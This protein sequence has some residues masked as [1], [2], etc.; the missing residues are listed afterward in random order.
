MKWIALF[1]FIIVVFII[2]VFAIIANIKIIRKLM[3]A[4]A[5]HDATMAVYKEKN[6]MYEQWLRIMYKGQSISK[7][8]KASGY[9]HAALYGLGEAGMLLV[10]EFDQSGIHIDYIL[11]PNFN[12]NS[13]KEHIVKR[14]LDRLKNT[15]VMIITEFADYE[16]ILGKLENILECPVLALDDLLFS[17][18]SY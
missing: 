15:D 7:Y 6:D 9:S 10:K 5:A 18:D 3:H 13:Y 8:I 1:A 2:L 12:R 16:I 11:E 4:L 14:D 17:I